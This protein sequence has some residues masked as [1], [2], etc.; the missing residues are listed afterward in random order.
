[1]RQSRYEAYCS[2]QKNKSKISHRK[3]LPQ[4]KDSRLAEKFSPRVRDEIACSAPT[5]AINAS[6]PE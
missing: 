4:I 5:E 1:M 6:K 2:S 3:V